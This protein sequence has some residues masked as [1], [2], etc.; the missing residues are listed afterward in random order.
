MPHIPLDEWIRLLGDFYNQY[1]YLIVFLSTVGENTALLGF[2]LPGNSLA[3]L[4]AFYARQGVL[5]LVWV[6]FFATAG[7]VLGYHI[8]YL[9]GR[10]ILS[11]VVGKWSTS[12]LGR[13]LRLAGRLRL[14]RMFLAKYGGR[15]ILASHISGTLRSFI[16][17]SAGMA[18]VT[19]L[20]FLGYELIAALLWNIAYC[21]LGYFIAVEFEQLHRL[22]ERTTWILLG[23]LLV[24][25]IACCVWG[26]LI[27][28]RVRQAWRLSRSK[29]QRAV[30]ESQDVQI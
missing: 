12:R 2:L 23:V 16:A 29:R 10:F 25:L 8:D 7:T 14:T 13:R 6:I 4:G 30:L 26:W 17:L 28:Q 18:R 9:F 19:Y 11:H 15:A 27:K 5:N 3:L 24:A 21:L 22:L 1:G 20:R